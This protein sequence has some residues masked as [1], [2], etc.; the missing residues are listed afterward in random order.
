MEQGS[1]LGISYLFSKSGCG[2]AEVI[3]KQHDPAEEKLQK[4]KDKWNWDR[5]KR[6]DF[7]NQRLHQ[8]NEGKA[9]INNVNAA[10]V[11]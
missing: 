4:A 1:I 9:Y 6:L 8:K 10:I 2:D 5:R 7:I 11:D 3:H